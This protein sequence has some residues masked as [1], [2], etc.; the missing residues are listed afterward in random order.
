MTRSVEAAGGDEHAAAAR[1]GRPRASGLEPDARSPRD[2]IL[3]VATRLFADQGY[4]QTTM[5][6][7]ARAAGLQQSSLY[8]W[9]K[10]K[11]FILQAVLAVNRAPLEFIE[12]VGAGSGS[13]ALKLYR[14][15]RFDTRQLCESPCDVLELAPLATRQPEVFADYW[16][17]RQRLHDWVVSLVRAAI[18]EGEFTH[19]DPNLT[20]LA[21][22]SLDEGLQHWVRHAEL[23]Q[24]AGDH[25]FCYAPIGAAEAAE[26]S[27]TMTLRGLLRRPDDVVVLQDA[28]ARWDDSRAG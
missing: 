11:E 9:F 10:R 24:P 20:A 26:F 3:S 5:S 12:R 19:V 25:A 4:D 18:D 23:H 1:L 28:A 27:A 7:I 17:D 15:I 16:R 22:L 21:L 6:Q 2:Q 8:Y 14:L 13:P